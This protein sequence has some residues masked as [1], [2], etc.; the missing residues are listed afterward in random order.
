M[1]ALEVKSE[2]AGTVCKIDRSAGDAVL[3]DDILIVVESMK[4]EIPIVAPASGRIARI[5]V[6]DGDP[7]S[8]G[9]VVAIIQIT[10]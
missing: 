2:I 1:P 4:M 7:V 6:V 9:Q 10:E 8:D 3:R 5:A